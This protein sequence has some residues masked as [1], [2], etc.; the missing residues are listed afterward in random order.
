VTFG[1]DG[2]GDSYIEALASDKPHFFI[3]E[4]VM[5]FAS[6]HPS[7][8]KAPLELFLNEVAAIKGEDGKS[9]YAVRV[10]KLNSQIWVDLPRERSLPSKRVR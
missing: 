7:E 4:N 8:T 3:F 1:G 5:G 9:L 6:R 10:V 2:S